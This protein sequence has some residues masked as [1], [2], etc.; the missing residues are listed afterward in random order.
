MATGLCCKDDRSIRFFDNPLRRVKMGFTNK[1]RRPEEETNLEG[2]FLTPL[3]LPGSSH[4]LLITVISRRSERLLSPLQTS[5]SIY[6]EK[7]CF[8]ITVAKGHQ[9]P[10][11]VFKNQLVWF[12]QPVSHFVSGKTI[13]FH[14][15]NSMILYSFINCP[16]Y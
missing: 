4:I 8:L 11:T 10:K 2:K 16:K 13:I 14:L 15:E 12:D 7:T 9:I 1:T 6:P 5:N 3:H